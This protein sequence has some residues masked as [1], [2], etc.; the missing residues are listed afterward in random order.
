MNQ[1]QAESP[2]PIYSLP[3]GATFTVT[4]VS[5]SS[6]RAYCVLSGTPC[7]VWVECD[8]SAQPL[9]TPMFSHPAA[10]STLAL[11]CLVEQFERE[12]RQAQHQR[13]RYT[14]TPQ[15]R[16][17]ALSELERRAVKGLAK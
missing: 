4:H 1:S 9:E 12:T 13:V 3:S 5:V 8:S 10:L 14:V 7:G 11:Q 2:A 17:A 15:Q 16:D 6:S